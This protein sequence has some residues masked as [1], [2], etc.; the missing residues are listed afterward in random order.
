MHS[1]FPNTLYIHVVTMEI[2]SLFPGVKRL[3]RGL[4]NLLSSTTMVKEKVP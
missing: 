2:G 4:D 3:G 1:D